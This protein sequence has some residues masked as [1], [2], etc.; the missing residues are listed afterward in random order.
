MGEKRAVAAFPF[1]FCLAALSTGC[2]GSIDNIDDFLDGSVQVDGGN[3]DG[4]IADSGVDPCD[5]IVADVLSSPVSCASSICHDNDNPS[6]GLDLLSDDLIG[7]LTGE[8]SQN[9]ACGGAQWINAAAPEESLLYT[10]LLGDNERPCG[11]RM[12]IGGALEN[13]EIQCVLTWIE[14]NVGE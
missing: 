2:P 10:K 7:R 11:T 12:P 14:N 5:S 1:I 13:A 8:V 3:L 6:A 4:G 9:A